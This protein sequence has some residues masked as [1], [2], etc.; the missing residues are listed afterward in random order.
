MCHIKKL[1]FHPAKWTRAKIEEET[2][3]LLNNKLRS[4]SSAPLSLLFDNSKA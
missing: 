4:H 3:H 2:L 1:A